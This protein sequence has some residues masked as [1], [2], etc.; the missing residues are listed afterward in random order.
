MPSLAVLGLL[1]GCGRTPTTPVS[2]GDLSTRTITYALVDID[3]LESP[4]AAG[5]HRFT[6]T[7][8]QADD[9]CTR[10]VDGVTATFNGQPMKLEPGGVSDSGGRETC[11]PTRAW[12]DFD[13][14]VWDSEPI[15]DARI[16]FQGQD[17]SRSLSLIVQSAK[18]KR[19][20]TFQGAGTGAT[21]RQGQTYTYR[22]EPV[23]ETPDTVNASLLREGGRA[24]GT[25]QLTQDGSNVSFTLPQATPVA[26]HLLTL[27]GSLPGLALE[28]VGVAGCEGTIF[29]ST[30]FQVAVAP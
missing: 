16:F 11:D 28:C 25:L 30:D 3:S 23:E 1:A 22:W 5:S 17:G 26:N 21:L 13:P 20:F 7:L 8:S 10:L 27:S 24:P 15:E 2:L 19:H 9:G 29:H 18:A 6:V 12:F 4:D 14:A